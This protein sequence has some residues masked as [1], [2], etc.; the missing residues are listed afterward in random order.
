M[1]HYSA[2][3]DK[4]SMLENFLIYDRSR[5]IKNQQE[6]LDEL[7]QRQLYKPTGRDHRSQLQ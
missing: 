1:V 4:L 5:A 2:K 3:L 6:L 7:K